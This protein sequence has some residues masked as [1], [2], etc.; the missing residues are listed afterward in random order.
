[1]LT[2]F[3][4]ELGCY[5]GEEIVLEIFDTLP[6]KRKTYTIAMHR[7]KAVYDEI[8]RMLNE[9]ILQ[10]DE[11]SWLHPLVIVDKPDGS[12]RICIDAAALNNILKPHCHNPPKVDEI[13][14]QQKRFNYICKLDFSQH[15]VSFRFHFRRSLVNYLVYK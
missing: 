8:Q 1:M 9:G 15:K 4:K 6:W 2:V 5:N 14:L 10:K 3:R 13:L 7:R 12:I 11:T